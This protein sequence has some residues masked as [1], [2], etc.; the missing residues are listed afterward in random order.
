MCRPSFSKTLRGKEEAILPGFAE[1]PAWQA[2]DN[3]DWENTELLSKLRRPNHAPFVGNVNSQPHLLVPSP[4]N[5]LL[6]S[7]A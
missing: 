7:R 5:C 1:A 3:T 6:V 4:A 2:T